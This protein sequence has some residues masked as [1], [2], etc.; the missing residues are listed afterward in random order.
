M[1]SHVYIAAK[2]IYL[3]EEMGEKMKKF[4]TGYV[5]TDLTHG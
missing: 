5:E 4:W 2:K 1:L 3:K